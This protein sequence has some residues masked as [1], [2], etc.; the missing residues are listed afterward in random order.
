VLFPSAWTV[1]YFGEQNSG[2]T[3]LDLPADS[4]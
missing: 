4:A 3:L 1:R 2:A